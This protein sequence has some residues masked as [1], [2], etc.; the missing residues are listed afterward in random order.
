MWFFKQSYKWW[1]ILCD[2]KNGDITAASKKLFQRSKENYQ[3]VSVLSIISKNFQKKISKQILFF[4]DPVLSKYQFGFWNG[5]SAQN[6]LLAMLRKCKWFVDNGKAFGVLLTDLSKAFH[7][8]LHELMIANLNA[9]RFSIFPL[10]LMQGYL[11]E[12][13]KERK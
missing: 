11:S 2:F 5:F 3:P 13:K 6:C 9:Y 4:M 7:C 8:L 1:E 12:K 10:G